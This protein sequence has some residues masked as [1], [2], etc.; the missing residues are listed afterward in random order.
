MIANE[1]GQPAKGLECPG[2]QDLLA[3]SHPVLL[4]RLAVDPFQTN[5]ARCFS[6]WGLVSTLRQLHSGSQVFLYCS[7]LAPAAASSGVQP[8]F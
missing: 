7:Y 5:G 2:W 4:S 8:R 6:P 1:E 3:P